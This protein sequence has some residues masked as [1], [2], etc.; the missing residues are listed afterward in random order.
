[1]GDHALKLVRAVRKHDERELETQSY[2][3]IFSEH[4]TK[5]Q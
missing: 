5:E 3:R 1:M 2:I 4:N